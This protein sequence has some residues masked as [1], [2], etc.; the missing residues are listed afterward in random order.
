MSSLGAAVKTAPYGC[1]ELGIPG[2]RHFI[3]K[4]RAHVQ[5]TS[6]VWDDQYESLDAQRRYVCPDDSLMIHIESPISRLPTSFL[7]R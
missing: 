6:P 2:L 3:Y 7:C 1:S 4:N 5:V